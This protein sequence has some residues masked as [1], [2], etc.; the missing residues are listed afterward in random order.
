MENTK[1]VWLYWLNFVDNIHSIDVKSYFSFKE[2]QK[3]CLFQNL[4]LFFL[5]PF[6]FCTLLKQA[7]IYYN[8]LIINK[9]TVKIILEK[10]K[11]ILVRPI[12]SSAYFRYLPNPIF[13]Y[14]KM[15]GGL[16]VWLIIWL[17]AIIKTCVGVNKS[18]LG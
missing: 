3:Q 5:R 7:H 1:Q 12:R 11:T 14:I 18:P 15:R 9:F 17:Y 4:E 16:K 8:T 10:C 2:L 13:R 6:V